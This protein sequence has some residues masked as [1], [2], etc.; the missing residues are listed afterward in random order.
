MAKKEEPNL[1]HLNDQPPKG[2]GAFVRANLLA[3]LFIVLPLYIT[4]YII[5]I[6][7]GMLDSAISSL[8]PAKYTPSNLLPYDI[9]GVEILVGIVIL[10]LI[11]AF[12][13][14]VVGIKFVKWWEDLLCSI[15][16]VRTIYSSVKQIIDTL[17]KSNSRSFREVVLLEYPRKG[18]WAIAFVTGETR[19]EIQ[20]LQ[21]EEVVNIFLPTTPNPTSGFLL[22]VPRKD[23]I[24]LHMTVD[25][26][27]KM[28]ISGGIV[29]PSKAE[30][31]AAMRSDT[32]S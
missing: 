10:V 7:V 19:G 31:K 22:I 29:T 23:L 32:P 27:V 11:G 5:K 17:S 28:V 16:W 2:F 20:D 14:N 13:R 4:F 30:G 12:A 18:L 3:G 1:Q 24:P 21:K 9:F 8:F 26:G 6:L 25:Q 15:P